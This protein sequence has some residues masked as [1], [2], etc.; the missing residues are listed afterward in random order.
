MLQILAMSMRE[1][2]VVRVQVAFRLCHH[3]P[4]LT[5]ARTAHASATTITKSFLEFRTFPRSRPSWNIIA[6]A[7]HNPFVCTERREP[8]GQERD[9]SVGRGTLPLARNTSHNMRVVD[10]SSGEREESY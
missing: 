6:S 4:V 7:I 3:P 1:A 5:Q 8:P 2:I 10:N 9:E